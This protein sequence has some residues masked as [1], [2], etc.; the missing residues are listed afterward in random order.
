MATNRKHVYGDEASPKKKRKDEKHSKKI[1]KLARKN[2]K[3]VK[4]KMKKAGDEAEKK[5]GDT[6]DVYRAEQDARAKA[7][8]KNIIH[9]HREKRIKKLSYKI[10]TNQYKEGE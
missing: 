4:R 7:R 1:V 5:G 10:A 2:I 6:R 8:K 3:L 9:K